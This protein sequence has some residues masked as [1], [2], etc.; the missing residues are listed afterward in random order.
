[1][2]KYEFAELAFTKGA[3]DGTCFISYLLS[4]IEKQSGNWQN[5]LNEMGLDGWFIGGIME[6]PN[7]TSILLQRI[8]SDE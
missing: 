6:Y 3:L 2:N 7:I 8:K 1:M 5:T 4:G